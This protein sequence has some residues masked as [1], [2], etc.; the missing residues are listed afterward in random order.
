MSRAPARRKSGDIVRR[1]RL[2]IEVARDIVH[3]PQ[4]PR[5]AVD[6]RAIEVEDREAI[7]G[8]RFVACR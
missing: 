4:E 3:H 1:N 7:A 5:E 2:E 6:Q 8:L